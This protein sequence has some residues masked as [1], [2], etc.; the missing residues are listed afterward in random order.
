MRGG[1]EYGEAWNNGG[2]R[3]NLQ[4]CMTDFQ[5]RKLSQDSCFYYH[6]HFRSKKVPIWERLLL[7][8]AEK[9]RH[10]SDVVIRY[11]E[12]PECLN[13]EFQLVSLLHIILII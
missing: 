3:E 7:Q 2:K 6:T 11:A 5:V 10:F 4:N 8:R 12:I 1:G 9:G 13:I